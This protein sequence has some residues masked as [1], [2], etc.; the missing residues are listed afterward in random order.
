MAS[1]T[2][3]ANTVFPAATVVSVYPRA[4]KILGQAPSGS[5]VT[6]GT[7][8]A[9]GTVSFT[10]LAD[11]TGYTAYALV[12]AV[13]VY[14]DFVT[15]TP[16]LPSPL[17][18]QEPL[19][20]A[21]R[22]L[23]LPGGAVTETLT[24]ADAVSNTAAPVS[25][26]LL[27]A[28][29]AVLPKGKTITRVGFVAGTTAGGTLTHQVFSVYRADTKALLG[30]TGD[31]VAT[32]WAA[33]AVKELVL[34]TPV[35]PTEDIPVYFG[36]LVTATTVPTLAGAIAQSAALN[37][38]TP[39]IAATADAGLAGTPASVPAVAGALTGV[40]GTPYAYVK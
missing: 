20:D 40:V 9:D 16:R 32:A 3:R 18:Q 14:I 30:V 19:E 2:L 37:A 27:L 33:N 4:N 17:S 1:I 25:G 36:L 21:R 24:R 35:T 31:D 29:G 23:W 12:S 11:G 26:T 39:V 7:V 34:A 38:L 28:G 15:E 10:G 22:R 5:A 8:A 13:N 6:T